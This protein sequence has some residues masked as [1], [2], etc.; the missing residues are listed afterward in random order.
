MNLPY[1]LVL[2]PPPLTDETAREMLAFLSQLLAALQ[3]HY[4]SALPPPQ[5]ATTPPQPDL[6]DDFIDADPPF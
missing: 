6:F 5:E 2:D 1:P 3:T 4:A